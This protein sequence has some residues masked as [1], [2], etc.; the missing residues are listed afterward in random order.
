MILDYIPLNE[1]FKEALKPQKCLIGSFPSVAGL[2]PSLIVHV[3]RK[4]RGTEEGKVFS[5]FLFSFFLYDAK[6]P[7]T[8]I[9]I[10]IYTKLFFFQTTP[11]V[12]CLRFFF[13]PLK[14]S[15]LNY[16]SCFLFLV[17]FAVCHVGKIWFFPYFLNVFVE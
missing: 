9:R 6:T 7:W 8:H 11:S 1:W 12:K 14:L 3:C 4:S 17:T 16:D 13:L 2:P 15:S 5:F 10:M